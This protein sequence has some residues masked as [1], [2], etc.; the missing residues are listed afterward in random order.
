MTDPQYELV[1]E[2]SNQP[3]KVGKLLD[4]WSSVV[5]PDA[6]LWCNRLFLFRYYSL[7]INRLVYVEASMART[8]VEQFKD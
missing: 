6:I 3:L 1:N 4:I 7:A 8:G 2:N 5:T